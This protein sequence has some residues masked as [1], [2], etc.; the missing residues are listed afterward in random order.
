MKNN[1]LLIKAWALAVSSVVMVS[2]E[3]MDDYTH[4]DSNVIKFGVD[5]DADGAPSTRA[6]QYADSPVVMLGEGGSDTLYLHASIDANT[7]TVSKEAMAGTRGVPINSKNFHEKCK[8]FGVTAYTEDGKLYMSNEKVDGYAN[9]AWSPSDGVRYWPEDQTLDFYAY[10]PYLF[11]NN[12]QFDNGALTINRADHTMRFSYT[13]PTNNGEDAVAQPDIMFAYAACSRSTTN[14]RGNVPLEFAHALAAVKFVANDIAGCTINRITLKGL[15]GAGECTFTP[16]GKDGK[17]EDKP[18]GTFAWNNLGDKKDFTQTFDVPLNDQQ[19]G[20]QDITDVNPETTFMMIPQQL[21]GATVEV[22]LTT[23]KDGFQHTLEGKLASGNLTEWKAGNIYTYKI[24]SESINWTYVFDV[25]PSITLPLG[26]TS[27]VYQV[28]SYRYRTQNPSVKEAVPWEVTDVTVSEDKPLDNPKGYV[29]TFT[30]KGEGIS[31]DQWKGYDI[32][33]AKTVMHT[34]CSADTQLKENATKGSPG[35]PYD[36]STE[37]GSMTT[38]N[39][40]VVNAAGTYKLPLVYGNAIVNGS[41]NRQAYSDSHFVDYKN[42]HIID[43]WIKSSGTPK[44]ATLVWSDGFYMFNDVHLD[45]DYLVFTINKDYIQQAN[46]IVAVRDASGTIMWSWHI[47]VTER[48]INKTHKVD[49]WSNGATY[50]MMSSNL[51]WVDGKQVYYDPR[52]FKFTF[53]Q[54]KTGEEKTMTVTQVGET[55]DYKDA[56]STYYQWGRKDPIVALKNRDKTGVNDYRRLDTPT[57]DYLYKTQPGWVTSADGIKH[58]NVYYVQNATYSS[59]AW[60]TDAAYSPKLWNVDGTEKNIWVASSRKTVY[61]PSPK[62]FKVPVPRAFSVF[63]DGGATSDNVCGTLNGYIDSATPYQYHVYTK[64]ND[65]GDCIPFTATGQR[66]NRGNLG[67]GPGSLWAMYGVY[68]WTNAAQSNG[69]SYSF[70]IRREDEVNQ[71]G[72]I[73]KIASYTIGFQGT[74]T[75]ARPVRPFKE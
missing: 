61:D 18:S 70:V 31:N 50:D 69:T 6:T 29:T 57:D 17:G 16:A 54:K 10:A 2:C 53:K 8:N 37:G 25:T 34:S 65:Q 19:T 74:Q 24:S 23:T 44:D 62:G 7:A 20:E 1:S 55:F 46:A 22:N 30:W 63:V 5:A 4:V 27:D 73:T 14:E 39:C 67:S 12:K 45:G 60:L 48:N 13:V 40:Y 59:T 42:E 72:S 15:Y 47:W 36:L 43:P 28:K 11:K 66:S 49:D 3:V 33:V 56:G 52:E 71:D 64:K 26:K 9:G 35:S 75:M 38:A 58:P 32:G 68:Y 41:P 21:E 51:G